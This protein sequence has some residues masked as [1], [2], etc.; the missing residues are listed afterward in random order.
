MTEEPLKPKCDIDDLLCQLQVMSYLKGMKNLI[1]VEKF[2]AKYPEFEQFGETITDRIK[3]QDIVIRE[4][5]EKCGL[6]EPEIP[7]VKEQE[8]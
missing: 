4:A 7:Q 6:A 1:G 3:E 5:L 2:R 8:E